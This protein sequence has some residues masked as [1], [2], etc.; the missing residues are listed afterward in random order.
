MSLSLLSS[1]H[2]PTKLEK[3]QTRKENV[4]HGKIF[5]ERKLSKA[6][7]WTLK[8]FLFFLLRKIDFS[9][10]PINQNELIIIFKKKMVRITQKEK[11]FTKFSNFL[12]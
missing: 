12:K 2:F 9:K 4:G 5:C 7:I 11:L 3:V 10:N 8:L 6:K 1:H